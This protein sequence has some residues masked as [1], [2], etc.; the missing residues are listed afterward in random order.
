MNFQMFKLVLEK[1]EEPEI[2]LPTSAGSLKKQESS[3]KTSISAFLTMPKPLT[4]WITINWKI[5]KEIGIPDHLTCLLRN[6]YAGQEA[7]V[8]TGHGTT[9]WF[10]IGKGVCQGCILLPCLFNLY[11]EYIMRNTGL[12]E[13]EAGIKIAGRNINN[14][15]YADDTT[16]MEESEEELKSFLMKVKEETEKVGSKLNIQKTKIMVSSPITSWQIDG[17]TVADFIFWGSK[18]TADGDCSHE[19]KRHLLLGRK[20]MTNLDSILKS[21]DIPLPTKVHL[22]KAMVF[23]VVMYGFESWNIKKAELQG[24]DAFELWCWRRLLRVPW[25]ARRSNQSIL[26]EIS[27][28][29]SL[30]VLMLKLKLQY[31]GHLMRRTDSFEK[32]LMLGK[33]EGRR[34]RGRQKMRWLDGII[35]TMDMSLGGLRELVMDREAWCAAVHGVAKSQTQLSD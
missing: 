7:T 25:T 13:A 30:E 1:A 21:R 11:T 3:R 24:I 15:R 2:K 19:I 18:I 22:V 23:P 4:V 6:L 34:R 8:R 26:K 10:Q 28:G 32:T 14:L 12:E 29:C 16:L 33:I 17:E 35:D 20:V 31:F 5:L 9:D 27:P